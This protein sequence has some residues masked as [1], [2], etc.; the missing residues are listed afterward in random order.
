MSQNLIN[1][2]KQMHREACAI[3]GN[4][5]TDY[6]QVSF[7]KHGPLAPKLADQTERGDLPTGPGIVNIVDTSRA[8][9]AYA[10]RV[11]ATPPPLPSK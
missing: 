7:D 3:A 2:H 9:A 4:R 1:L 6:H 8:M 11:E 10:A 5:Y